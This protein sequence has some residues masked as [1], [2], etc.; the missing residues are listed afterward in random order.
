M[1][2]NKMTVVQCW[3]DGVTADVGVIEILRKHAAKATF[4]L[5]AGTHGQQRKAGWT[6]KTRPS[7]VSCAKPATCTPAP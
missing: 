7:W 1:N 4:N 6:Y 2:Q 5:N 3:D